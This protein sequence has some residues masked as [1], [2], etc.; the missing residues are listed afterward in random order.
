MMQDTSNRYESKDNVIPSFKQLCKKENGNNAIAIFHDTLKVI[1]KLPDILLQE[2]SEGDTRDQQKYL[3]KT[4]RDLDALNKLENS[5]IN[6]DGLFQRNIPH[7]SLEL[8]V[9]ND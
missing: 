2:D 7:Y 1:P 5:R 4:G 3:S 9:P 6:S 8:T